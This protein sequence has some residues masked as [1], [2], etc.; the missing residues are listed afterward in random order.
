MVLANAT[1]GLTAGGD[2][3]SSVN[4]TFN[5]PLIDGKLALRAVF[6]NDSRGGYIDNVPGAMSV[7]VYQNPPMLSGTPPGK[8]LGNPLAVNAGLAGTNTNTAAYQG[9]R[10]SALLKINDQWDALLQYN[11]QQFNAHGYWAT[12][13]LDPN[14]KALS[15]FETMAFSPAYS[16][17]QYNS[18]ALT[19]NGDLG[20]LK[21]VYT[22][23]LPGSPHRWPAGLFQLPAFGAWFLLRLHWR[24]FRVWR[25][26][27]ALNKAD[28][29]LRTSRCL[30]RPGTEY[31]S[32]PR[33]SVDDPDRQAPARPGRRL[34]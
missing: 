17:D 7:P 9:G 3:N 6:F 21:A 15:S 27:L 30:A 5:V 2:P 14:G 33:A 31:A 24:R 1:Y 10:L 23:Q 25:V 20:F 22:W 32:E 11:T 12:E 28:Y 26:L 19:I 4:A 34:L 16:K 18:T 8:A 29:V 13:P